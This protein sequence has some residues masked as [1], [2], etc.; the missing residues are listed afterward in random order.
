MIV[1]ANTLNTA[2]LVV[3][4]LYVQIVPPQNLVLPG[5]PTN[6]VGVVGSASWG[7]VNTATIIGDMLSYVRQFGTPVARAYDMGT[8]VA[9]AV[10]QGAQSFVC[11][12]VTDGTDTAATY[13]LGS[14]TADITFTALYTGSL[15][16]NLTVSLSTG[17]KSGSWKAVVS[18]PGGEPE[19]FNNLTGTG[20][21]FWSGLANAINHGNG[22]L[23][24]PSQLIRATAGTGTD[25]PSATTYTLAGGTDGAAVNA[26]Q[27]VGT[28]GSPRTG[29]YVLEGRGCSVL[30]LC[31]M[32]DSTQW[33]TIDGFALDQGM[34]A[35]LTGPSGDTIN[36][37][38][39]TRNTAG[40]DSYASKLMFGD[41]I[42]WNDPF[43]AVQRYVSPQGFVAGRL[44][45]LSPE[46]SSLNKPIYAVAGTQKSGVT[47]GQSST[48][49]DAELQTL[50]LAGIDV[51]T[52][53]GGGGVIMWTCR[54][55]HN[56]S[57]NAA[58]QGDN[59]TRLTN[60]IAT[61]LNNGMGLY[62]GKVINQ[63]LANNVKATL[64]AFLLG[65]V[66]QGILG[67]DVDD[68]GLPFSV[69]CAI[70]PGTNNPPERTKLGF[71][72][73]DITVQYQAINEKF[74]LNIESGQTVT[75]ARQTLQNGQVTN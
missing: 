61:S 67:Q 45:N 10:Q 72:Q 12:R 20:A 13:T 38:V 53:P 11:V 23:R 6:T 69:N 42:A 62:L 59:Y 33:T 54:S 40:L 52:N 64:T 56:S 44:A 32:T 5:A 21:A 41:W 37:A 18:V 31:D 55:G 63:Q 30:D 43:N 4:D 24:G 68:G 71:M 26:A 15:G 49:S 73:A 50:I 22:P 16:N 7:P 34:Y 36:N 60:F 8:H 46:Q 58:V 48:Y 65:L 28:D 70:G 74:I 25:A 9:T 29:M 57:S 27:V 17:S 3:P 51:V 75:I 19:I 1:A 14:P 47:A 66:G 39:A 35:I 2:A